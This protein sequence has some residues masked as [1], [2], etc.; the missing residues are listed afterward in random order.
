MMIVFL[1][2]QGIVEGDAMSGIAHG[3]KSFFGH[4][5][6]EYCVHTQTYRIA[7]YF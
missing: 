6:G 4:V 7:G 2:F 1:L 5:V 3:M